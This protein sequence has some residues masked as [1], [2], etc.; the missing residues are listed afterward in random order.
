MDNRKH[1]GETKVQQSSLIP[2]ASVL[3]KD[4]AEGPLAENKNEEP[5]QV[6]L[7]STKPASE[8]KLCGKGNTPGCCCCHLWSNLW[9]EESWSNQ[10]SDTFCDGVVWDLA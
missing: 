4:L 3:G 7:P 5:Y 8:G 2:R 10:V 1:A 9:K 6:V